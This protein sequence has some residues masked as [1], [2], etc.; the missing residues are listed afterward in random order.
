MTEYEA[1]ERTN[2]QELQWVSYNEVQTDSLE[3]DK[4][5]V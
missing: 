2:N 5:Q 1:A 4:N 3:P